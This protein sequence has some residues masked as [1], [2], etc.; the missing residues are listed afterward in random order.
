[1]AVYI[2][3]CTRYAIILDPRQIQTEEISENPSP[4]LQKCQSLYLST[5]GEL[6]RLLAL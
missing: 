5:S 4:V 3:I 1:V 2:F 6:L